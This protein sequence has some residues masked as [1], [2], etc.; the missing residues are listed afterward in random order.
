MPLISIIIPTFNEEKR[1]DFLLASLTAQTFN[2]YESIVSDNASKD[3]TLKIARKYHC[4]IV[5]G[6]LPANGRNNGVKVAKGKLLIFM[7]ADAVLVEKDALEKLLGEFQRRN[8]D[9]GSAL[10]KP[11]HGL[12]IDS[13]LHWIWNCWAFST[14]WSYPHAT[15]AFIICKKDVFKKV[16]GFDESIKVGEDHH[17]VAKVR[18]HGYKYRILLS[19]VLPLSVRR[20]EAEGRMKILFKI[21]FM[22]F[23]R[24]FFG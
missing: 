3:N 1:L 7:D 22:G 16:R 12:W 13:V 24:T 4:K 23:Y 5:K 18:L 2:D 10:V 8:L 20:F 6:G 14:Q 19:S 15:G 11:F 17:F 21:L 9:C